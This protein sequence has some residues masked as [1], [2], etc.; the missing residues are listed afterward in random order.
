MFGYAEGWK[1][2]LDCIQFIIFPIF[3]IIFILSTLYTGEYESGADQIILTSMYGKSKLIGAKNMAAFMYGSLFYLVNVIIMAGIILISYGADGGSLPI[4]IDNSSSP[5]PFTY[6]QATL[7]SF[8]AGYVIMLL[9]VALTLFI[10]ARFR[11]SVAVVA[12]MTVLLF[13]PAFISRS[14]VN[15]IYNHVVDILPYN[16]LYHGLEK[17]VSYRFGNIVFSY[18]SIRFIIY[19][20]ITVIIAPVIGRAFKYHQVN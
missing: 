17:I 9:F 1:Q 12:F 20:V 16:A 19:S 2:L 10:S 4:Q 5:Y 7:I 3:A 8:A 13:I 6:F 11:K 15:E 14:Q 18:V